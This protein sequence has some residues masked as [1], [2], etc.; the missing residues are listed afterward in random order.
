MDVV[1]GIALSTAWNYMTGKQYNAFLQCD[2]AN[3]F[4]NK[5]YIS[6]GVARCLNFIIYGQS[7]VNVALGFDPN[8]FPQNA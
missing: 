4:P 1:V 2:C 5:G 7:H 6:G 8:P 3:T